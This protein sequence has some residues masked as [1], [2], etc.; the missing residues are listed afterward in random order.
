MA[1]AWLAAGWWNACKTT[2]FL[3]LDGLEL[4]GDSDLESTGSI[5]TYLERP[6]ENE[7]GPI[8]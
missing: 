2:Q 8:T 6:E 4:I 1:G 3:G 7:P 5:M